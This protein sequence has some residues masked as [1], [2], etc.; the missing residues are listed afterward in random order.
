MLN[1]VVLIGRLVRI[2]DLRYTPDGV[3]VRSFVLAVDRFR[4][5]ASGERESDFIPCVAFR[6]QAEL[7]EQFGRK[8]SLISVEGYLRTRRRVTPDGQQRTE[9]EVYAW[10]VRS[11]ERRQPQPPETP[12]VITP[13][14]QPI[15]ETPYEELEEEP[16]LS[17]LPEEVVEE[18]GDLPTDTS[19]EDELPF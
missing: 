8:G 3:P 13:T 1:V 2:S 19:L 17:E 12:T 7:L 16:T 18:L 4:R 5:D 9:I 15:S 11:L 10:R 6:R 14:T